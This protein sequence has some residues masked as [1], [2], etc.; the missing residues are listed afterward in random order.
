MET[1]QPQK[2]YNRSQKVFISII[3]LLLVSTNVFLLWQFF[4]KK[5]EAIHLTETAQA[6]SH[7]KDSLQLDLKKALLELDAIKEANLDLQGKLSGV[8]E[9]LQKKKAQIQKMINSGELKQAKIAL[10][11][12]KLEIRGYKVQIDSLKEINEALSRQNLSLNTN[13]EEE[14]GKNQNLS[15]ENTLLANKVAA[16]SVLKANITKAIG[17]KAGNKE[18]EVTKAKS[19]DKIKVCFTI[20]E[21][22]IVDKG[23]KTAYIRIIG[24]DGAVLSTS[25]ETFIYNGQ[26]SLY[27]MKEEFDY[28]NK[29]TPLCVYWSKGSA[30]A[31]GNY[32]AEVYSGGTQ[33]GSAK[34]Q[35]K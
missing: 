26:P 16:G 13:L 9:E 18:T 22:L 31:K 17:V 2:K 33:I 8:E 30:F 11:N 7:I 1:S 12:L 5:K 24:A 28:E 34:F 4:T 19:T 20:Q 25:S 15:K 29:E 10:A 6:L 23:L 32:T 14:K 35:L 27:T 21:N 3:I